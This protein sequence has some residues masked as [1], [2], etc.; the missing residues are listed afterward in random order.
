[1]RYLR[2][3]IALL[4]LLSAITL[5]AK[6]NQKPPAKHSTY[7]Y[8]RKT[9]FEKLPNARNEIIFLGNSITD[10][11]EWAELFNDLRV[12]NR[13]IS[14]DVTQ[15]VLD[16]LQEVVESKPA[17]IFIMIGV[18]DLAR[19]LSVDEVVSNYRKILQGI[20]SASP[21]TRIYIQSVLP[22]N[23]HFTKFKNHVNKT[24]QIMAVNEHLVKMADE[25]D[26]T[27]Y[28]DLFSPFATDDN[29]LNPEYTNDG[30][31]LTGDGYL[32]WKSLVQD[33]VFDRK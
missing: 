29:K 21:E 11:C 16:R 6:E 26:H 7:Y 24:E 14:G 10:G 12:K 22:V 27:V 15:G 19:G 9:L 5:T 4:L 1:M 2:Q 28:I 18:N 17:K 32:L 23:D 30:L 20:R 31:H 8:Q 13:G 25:F 33:Y 3:A